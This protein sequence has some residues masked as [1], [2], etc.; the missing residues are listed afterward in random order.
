MRSLFQVLMIVA[1]AAGARDV[2]QR[3]GGLAYKDTKGVA[4]SLT[5]PDKP[6]VVVLWVTP[7]PYC[8]RALNVLDGLRR[9]YPKAK[10]DVVG[11]YLNTADAATVDQIAGQEGHSIT[12]AQGQPTHEFVE[13]MT[14]HLSFR[15]PG[16]DIYVIGKN[17]KY[18]AV[19][20][21]DLN[22]PDDEIAQRVRAI[23]A[24]KH[25]VKPRA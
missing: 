15:A 5:S 23:L 18:Q 10:L 14:A 22:V 9:E 4:H 20:S 2:W 8:A 13:A 25:G 17:G 3:H 12:M 1:L 7:C 21:S 24:D 16:R 6:A 19:D 11:L